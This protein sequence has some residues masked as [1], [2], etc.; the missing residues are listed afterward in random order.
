MRAPGA[1]LGAWPGLVGTGAAVALTV[2]ALLAAR[3]GLP[4][5]SVL[6]LSLVACLLGL[7][8]AKLY[9]MAEHPQR[10][11]GL[12][13]MSSGMC[14]QGFV[15]AAVGAVVAGALL[16]GLPVGRL[17]DVT[18]P[19]LLFGMA[20]GRV[21]CF[22]GGCCAGRPTASRCGLWSSDRKLGVRRI[23]TQLFESAMAL[24][25]GLVAL[26]AMVLATPSPGG[27]VFVAGIAAYTFG[28]QLLFPLRALPRNTAHGRALT[29]SA[30]GLVAVAA[31]GAAILA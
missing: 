6:L 9:Y 19:G 20:I 12:M 5:A 17:L 3:V 11:R 2:Q 14:I 22:L 25:I 31:V 4:V 8:G 23:P 28:R 27:L 13:N 7:A 26:L 29:M 16:L 21:G 1:R 18:A 24:V 15:L 30:S 10:W